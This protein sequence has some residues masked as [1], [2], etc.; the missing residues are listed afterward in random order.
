[1]NLYNFNLK[2]LAMIMIPIAI[3]M[4]IFD[5]NEKL[6]IIM[7]E[8]VY[9]IL[10]LDEW[11][12]SKDK[13]FIFTELDNKDGFVHL[14][15]AKQLMGTLHYYFKAS[16]TLILVEFK[17]TALGKNLIFEDPLPKTKRTGKFPHYY[18]KLNFD[19]ISKYWQIKRGSFNLP[20]EV[21]AEIEN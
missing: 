10:T 15:T 20:E 5:N 14:S 16:E 3:I 11:K 9:K 8:K 7:E 17:S 19:K 6:E 4:L 21:I 13:K 18:S 2:I 1:M 12:T